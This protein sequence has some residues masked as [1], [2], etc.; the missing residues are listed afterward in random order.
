MPKAFTVA[1]ACDSIRTCLMS[2]SNMSDVTR[3]MSCCLQQHGYFGLGVIGTRMPA[4][5]KLSHSCGSA[6]ILLLLLLLFIH[7]LISDKIGHEN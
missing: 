3:T 7:L 2:H 4:G 1:H 6:P 5:P